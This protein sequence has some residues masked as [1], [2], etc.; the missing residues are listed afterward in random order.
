MLPFHY[1]SL[2]FCTGTRYHIRG[3]DEQ[4]HVAN[5][6]ETEQV[7]VVPAQDRIYSFVQTRGSIPVF[8]SQAPDI[9]YK[10]KPRLTATEK[11]NVR[12]SFNMLLQLLPL[13]SC[14]S[15]RSSYTPSRRLRLKRTWTNS[16]GTTAS[17]CS[18]T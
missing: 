3:A 18:S 13:E 17:M 10:P 11:R 6:V 1:N 4:G 16:S 7:L 12:T 8:W 14:T 15:Q 5:F 9:T 2:L